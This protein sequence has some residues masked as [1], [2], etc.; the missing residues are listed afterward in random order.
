MHADQEDAFTTPREF[1]PASVG[2]GDRRYL[3]LVSGFNRRWQA[4]PEHIRL[5]GSTEQ[6]VRAVQEAVD[7]GKRLSIRS[8]GH[9]YGDFTYHA[10]VDIIVDLG[11]MNDISYDPHR[12]AFAVQSGAQLGRSTNGCSAAGA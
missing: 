2:P 9:S 7:T 12:K 4:A 5:V 8:G 11:M 6:V 3:D 10:D 1:G